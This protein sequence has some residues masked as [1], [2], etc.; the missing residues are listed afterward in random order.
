VDPEITN[1]MNDSPNRDV[2]VFTDALALPRAERTAYLDRACD[3]DV[4][5]R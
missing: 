5:L 1:S 2:E 3:G 4:E